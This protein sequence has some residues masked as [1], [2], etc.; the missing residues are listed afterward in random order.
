MFL[1]YT[2]R[3]L[4][5]IKLWWLPKGLR[6]SDVYCGV[7]RLKIIY[8]CGLFRGFSEKILDNRKCLFICK[9]NDWIENAS[10]L[11]SIVTITRARTRV[12]T[13]TAIAN[14]PWLGAIHRLGFAAG[15]T[16]SRRLGN[17]TR[18]AVTWRSRTFWALGGAFRR[19][20][21]A[22]WASAVLATTASV[23]AAA[24]SANELM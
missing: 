15:I 16:H 7:R 5:M 23:W 12:T 18:V 3:G 1:S 13:W 20:R 17:S 4:N 2:P 24:G 9:L 21:V 8:L 11:F 22:S 6:L 14:R 10:T 19:A